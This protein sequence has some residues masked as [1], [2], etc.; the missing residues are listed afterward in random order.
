MTTEQTAAKK[1]QREHKELYN[2]ISEL[3]EGD[4]LGVI[5]AIQRQHR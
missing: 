3:S 1:Y 2:Y 5:A 4:K